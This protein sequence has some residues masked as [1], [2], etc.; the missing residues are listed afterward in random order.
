MNTRANYELSVEK[1]AI[2]NTV[3]AVIGCAAAARE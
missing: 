3:T 1:R 2:G